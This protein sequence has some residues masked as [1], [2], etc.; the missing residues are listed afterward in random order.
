MLNMKMSDIPQPESKSTRPKLETGTY[1]AIVDLIVDLGVQSVERYE[2]KGVFDDKRRI[3]VGVCLPTEVYT[4]ESDDG[5]VEYCQ[6][7]G[8]EENFSPNDESNITK[9]Y[10]ALCSPD[11]VVSDMLGK[12]CTVTIGMTSG[13]KPKIM[14]ISSAM[15]G[16]SIK[17]PKGHELVAVGENEWDKVDDYDIPKFLKDAIKARVGGPEA[18]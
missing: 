5:D 4:V 17:L 6:V 8:K 7:I 16:T 15:K 18:V 14:S 12:A 2:E 1:P 3:W 9:Y 10:K 13:N 11:E